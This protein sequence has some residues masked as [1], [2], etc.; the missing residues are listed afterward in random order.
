MAL[1]CYQRHQL[2]RCPCFHHSSLSPVLSHMNA[3]IQNSWQ[4]RI[5][6]DCAL[7]CL[8]R[9]RLRILPQWPEGIEKREQYSGQHPPIGGFRQETLPLLGA[10]GSTTGARK[11]KQHQLYPCWKLPPGWKTG[12]FALSSFFPGVAGAPAGLVGPPLPGL[13]FPAGTPLPLPGLRFP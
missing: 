2:E 3:S 5:Y 1:R 8:A 4:P 12:A 13:R 6:S 7:N 9:T 10:A 11:E